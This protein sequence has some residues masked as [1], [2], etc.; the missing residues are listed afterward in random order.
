MRRKRRS[1]IK[2]TIYWILFGGTYIAYSVIFG[3]YVMYLP[4]LILA[5]VNFLL[6]MALE[7]PI[8][9][10]KGPKIKRV[11]SLGATLLSA[12]AIIGICR[13]VIETGTNYNEAYIDSLDYSVFSHRSSVSYD[14]ESGVYTVRAQGDELNILQLTD[15]HLGGS[16]TTIGT[17]RKAIDACYALIREAQPDLILVTGDIVYPIPYQ[18]FNKN[19]LKPVY[20][21]CAFMNNIGIPWA[22]VYGNHDTEAIAG[23]DVKSLEALYRHFKQQDDCPMLYADKQPN[24][25]GRYNQYL[26]IEDRAGSLNRLIFLIDS[27]DYVKDAGKVNEYDSVH[28]DQIEWYSETVDSV[29]AQE[30]GTVKSFVFMHIPFQEFAD[31]GRALAAGSGDAVYLFGENREA[32]SCPDH[33]SGFFQAI[34]DKG[35]T[36]AVFVGH[37]H[38]NNMGIRYKGVDLVYSKSIDYLAYPGIAQMT[39]QRGATHIT[40]LQNGEYTIRQ[41]DYDGSSDRP[42]D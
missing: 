38:V 8:S 29:S 21:F 22:M 31:A 39:E 14:R 27:N 28:Q 17:D 36:E 9:R 16:I 2:W 23:Y 1:I 4:V 26:R 20:Q 7:F 12:A 13:A 6:R 37:D 32:V 40:L 5:A 35:S 24:V 10:L 42:G 15:I 19:N 18:T 34:L 41:I 3:N 25:Y 30:G 11:L 33:N